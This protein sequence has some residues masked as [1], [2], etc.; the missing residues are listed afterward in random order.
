[1]VFAIFF[2]VWRWRAN[3]SASEDMECE[4]N[5]Q[6]KR[7]KEPHPLVPEY[8]SAHANRLGVHEHP[9]LRDVFGMKEPWDVTPGEGFHVRR[10][11]KGGRAPVRTRA[12][13][14]EGDVTITII[15]DPLNDQESADVAKEDLR[16]GV[17]HHGGVNVD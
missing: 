3:K 1:M 5:A 17:L 14:D 11:T 2:A 7:V 4:L 13:T 8:P 9:A 12:G 16:S 10:I 6:L 15:R